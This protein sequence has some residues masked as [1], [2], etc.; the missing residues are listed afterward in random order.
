MLIN[1]TALD[2]LRVGF[3]KNFKDGLGMASPMWDKIATKVPSTTKENKYGWLGKFPGMRQWIGARVLNSIK[4]H[5]YAIK[6]LPW[7]ETVAVDRDD[8]LDD[9]LG[10]Y[11][12]LMQ[13][14]G[15][16]VAAHPDQL[17][18]GALAAGFDT[19]CYDGQNFF[20]T[21]HPVLDE[22]GNETT[23]SN[24]G[25]G[26]GSPWFLLCTNR[27]LKPIIYQERKSPDFVA[28]DDPKSQN[29]FM[30]KEFVYGV[31][32][33]GNVGYGF[34]QMAQGSKQTLNKAGYKAA[35]EAILGRKGDHGRPLGLTPNLLVV[36]PSNEAA[37]LELLNA[38]RD[39]NGATN[40]YKGTA[41]LLVVPWLD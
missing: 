3:N 13:S 26:S 41:E 31:D 7:E 23:V 20:D 6:N 8:I 21:D 36:G 38:E 40:V 1:S 2:A 27:P 29:V 14:L 25:G 35:R 30:N 17:V 18:W 11:A 24:T 39:A 5:D 12:P 33:R 9:N 15:E 34:W 22:G 19:E 4:E 32:Y 16:G 37:A 10:V 28:M